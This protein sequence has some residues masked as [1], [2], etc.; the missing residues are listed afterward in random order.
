MSCSSS[1][2]ISW[3][4]GVGWPALDVIINILG[5]HGGR[6]FTNMRELLWHIL[7]LRLFSYGSNWGFF[8]GYSLLSIKRLK[9]LVKKEFIALGV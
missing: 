9:Q 8:G 5:G 3:S 2:G 4:M 6:M 7:F 1:R